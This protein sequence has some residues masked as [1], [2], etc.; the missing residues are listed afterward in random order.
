MILTAALRKAVRSERFTPIEA[1]WLTDIPCKSI[2]K[3]IDSGE[4]D[5]VGRAKAGSR[6]LG[7]GE[8]LYLALRKDLEGALSPGARAEV[9][10]SLLELTREDF[11]LVLR[12]T[13]RN[14]P[15]TVIE[16]AGGVL[17]V[18][19]RNAM[20]RLAKRL[21]EL[22]DVERTIVSDPDIRGGEP[23]FR[24]TRIPVYTIAALVEQGADPR[25]IREDYPSLNATGVRAAVVY[26]STRPKR[27]R[28]R[29]APWRT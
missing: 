17:R 29:K 13:E 16:L 14:W 18:D 4:V 22:R 8:L 21:A 1:G 7:F 11:A 25:E 26:A 3:I 10:A 24:G 15:K 5:R 20:R 28:P 27:G 23:V 6:F 19:I 2:N 9:Y 12:K